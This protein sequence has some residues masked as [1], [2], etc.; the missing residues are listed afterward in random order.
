MNRLINPTPPTSDPLDDLLGAYFKA[1]LPDPW[2][3]F[4]PP[5]PARTLKLA[6]AAPRTPWHAHAGKLALA[7]SVGL[8]FLGSW[9]LPTA[10]VPRAERP[11]TLPTIGPPSASKG[12]FIVPLEPEKRGKL[13]PGK[14]KSSLHLEQGEDGRTGLKITVEELPSNK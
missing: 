10:L 7:A 11:D 6:P 1:Q 5:T 3:A 4:V 8:L 14:V 2:P 9:L 13:A 12:G